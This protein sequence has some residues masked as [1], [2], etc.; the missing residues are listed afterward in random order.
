MLTWWCRC[1]LKTFPVQIFA[2]GR[3]HSPVRT[4]CQHSA[5]FGWRRYN[6]W[7]HS[8]GLQSEP[9]PEPE[10]EWDLQSAHIRIQESDLCWSPLRRK[11][12][13]SSIEKSQRV[14]M[15]IGTFLLNAIPVPETP[16]CTM[17]HNSGL[18][19]F[20]FWVCPPVRSSEYS[21]GQCLHAA[22]TC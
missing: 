8:A 3:R 13:S 15:S 6:C 16:K 5:Q 14:G 17:V 20:G 2:A 9:E 12:T 11:L 21:V 10:W 7:R 19:V 4:V 1:V 22:L 18:G